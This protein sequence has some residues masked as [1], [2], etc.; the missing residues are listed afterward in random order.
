M[1]S[2]AAS[3]PRVAAMAVTRLMVPA[4]DRSM[5]PRSTTMV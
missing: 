3:S 4:T 2:A 5:P 1:G